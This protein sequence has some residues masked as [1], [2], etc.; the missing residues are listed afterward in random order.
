MNNLMLLLKL[1]NAQQST[2]NNVKKAINGYFTERNYSISEKDGYVTIKSINKLFIIEYKQLNNTNKYIF[3]VFYKEIFNKRNFIKELYFNENVIDCIVIYD[4]GSNKLLNESY[5]I[6]SKLENILKFY[7]GSKIAEV[8]GEQAF[9]IVKKFIV[10]DYN[11]K[12]YKHMITSLQSLEL[13][14]LI[15]YIFSNPLGGDEINILKKLGETNEDGENIFSEEHINNIRSKIENSIFKDVKKIIN[16]YGMIKNIYAWRNSIAHNWCIEDEVFLKIREDALCI[17]REIEKICTE[18]EKRN[19][20]CNDI[21]NL[22]E[23]GVLVKTEKLKYNILLRIV[24]QLNS[25]FDNKLFKHL[26]SSSVIEDD[27]KLIF[28]TSDLKVIIY[29]IEPEFEFECSQEGHVYKI[30]IYF[31]KEQS[32]IPLNSEIYSLFEEITDEYIVLFDSISEMLCNKL[33]KNI[34]YVENLVRLY[35][36]ISEIILSDKPDR[37]KDKIKNQKSDLKLQIDLNALRISLDNNKLNFVNNDLYELDFITLLDKLSSPLMDKK[38]SKLMENEAY[39]NIEDFNKSIADL[40]SLD[41]NIERIATKWRYLYEIRTIVAH[42]FILTHKDFIEYK[43]IY[44]ETEEEIQSS[45]YRLLSR[46]IKEFDFNINLPLDPNGAI[47]INDSINRYRLELIRNSCVEFSCYIP[48]NIVWKSI[49]IIFKMNLND[50]CIFLT[51]NI[52]EDLASEDISHINKDALEL[53]LKKVL[54][55]YDVDYKNNTSTYIMLEKAI[56]NLLQDVAKIY[57]L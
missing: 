2:L 19:S 37:T 14:S 28:K 26:I 34:N 9:E 55:Y 43:N 7:L 33:Y 11:C 24:E 36:K 49:N 17:S 1:N 15:E 56:S 4:A 35:I 18:G 13:S 39:K 22:P 47:S 54:K 20:K 48:N 30:L 25:F 53:E 16:E 50:G 29:N 38:Y 40:S 42:N 41:N 44:L 51:K 27:N 5:S 6:L 21:D 10:K 23:I 52:V 31:D 32:E 8:Q 46:N 12:K 3:N 57:E 45:V